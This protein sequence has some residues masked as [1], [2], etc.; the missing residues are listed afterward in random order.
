MMPFAELI[1][2]I[3]LWGFK[4]TLYVMMQFEAIAKDGQDCR[5]IEHSLS[6]YRPDDRQ[7]T[8]I[9]SQL[10][11]KQAQ[12]RDDCWLAVATA[13]GE[14]QFAKTHDGLGL[15]EFAEPAWSMA[16]KSQFAS[17]RSKWEPYIR[18]ARIKNRKED[19]DE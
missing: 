16:D 7:W 8:I 10:A 11:K 14:A 4:I 17:L 1:R 12:L 6:E 3:D 18:K 5:T 19:A 2:Q 9:H 13:Y 15:C